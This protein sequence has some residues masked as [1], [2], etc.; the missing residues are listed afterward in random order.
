MYGDQGF[1][2][3]Q[4]AGRS[5]FKVTSE[6]PWTPQHPPHRAG[7]SVDGVPFHRVSKASRWLAIRSMGPRDLRHEADPDAPL[8]L[9]FRRAPLNHIL[10]ADRHGGRNRRK[11]VRPPI[12]LQ[13][14]QIHSHRLS[15]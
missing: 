6:I 13:I 14:I 7:Q 3:G 4:N 1:S 2:D 5:H 11:Q 15:V 12:V 8:Q 9:A 10:L